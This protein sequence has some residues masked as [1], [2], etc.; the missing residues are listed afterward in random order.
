M[1]TTPNTAFID[2]QNLHMATAKAEKPWDIDFVKF[3][4]Y[5]R[6]KYH[7]ETAYFFLGYT[8]NDLEGLY[9]K[10]QEAG[11]VLI[12][13]EH[14]S[15]MLSNKKGNVDTDIV[16]HIMKRLHKQ[17]LDGKVVLVS[18]DG[19]YRQLV[20]F[21]IE[22]KKF[23]KILHPSKKYASSLYKKLGSEFYDFLDRPDIKSRL[24][25]QKRKTS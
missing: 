2:G 12:F 20:D 19:D 13:R 24:I 23:L 3:R 14:N 11:F 5:L 10:I 22:E 17:E 25:K 4:R 1:S 18:N 16:F 6:E 21:L 9:T 7:I 8:I 15:F